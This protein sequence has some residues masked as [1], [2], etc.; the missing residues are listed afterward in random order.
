MTQRNGAITVE[1]DPTTELPS[2]YLGSDEDGAQ[3]GPVTLYDAIVDTAAKYLVEKGGKDLRKVVAELVEQRVTEMID[4][5]LPAI[6]EAALNEPLEVTDEWGGR[7]ASK[8]LRE[9][10]AERAREQ[11]KPGRNSYN[12]TT[13][14]KVIRDEVDRSL[15]TL[16]SKEVA[17][18][19]VAV[20]A[21][22]TAKAAELLATETMRQAG[23]R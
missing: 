16:L 6:F 14:D 12:D 21:K 22:L 2:G 4:A 8:T 20:K 9:V 13:M 17:A 10:I 15:H 18:A 7:K 1:I 11:M 23:I 19:K 3:Y 5:E